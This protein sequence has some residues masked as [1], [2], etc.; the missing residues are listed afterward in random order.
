MSPLDDWII[1]TCAGY[2][3]PPCRFSEPDDA[4]SRINGSPVNLDA[5]VVSYFLPLFR[6]SI[7]T[8]P[9]HIVFSSTDAGEQYNPIRELVRNV[10]LG[11]IDEKIMATRQLA[12]QL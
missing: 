6:N 2:I 9:I 7:E 8:C 3:V 10:A 1:S 4:L 12:L 11:T 5:E